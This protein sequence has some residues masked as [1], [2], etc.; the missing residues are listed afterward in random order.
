MNPSLNTVFACFL[1]AYEHSIKVNI[2]T[3]KI[4]AGSRVYGVAFSFCDI[5]S[6]LKKFQISEDFRFFF[7]FDKMLDLYSNK[8]HLSVN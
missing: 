6:V 4:H 7:F 2:Y 1:I 3:L 8:R 5:M